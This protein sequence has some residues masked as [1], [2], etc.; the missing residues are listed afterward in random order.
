MTEIKMLGDIIQKDL[1]EMNERIDDI[2][3]INED[4]GED[5]GDY[6][7][8]VMERNGMVDMKMYMEKVLNLIRLCG[9]ELMEV[10]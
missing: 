1:D 9:C 7:V 6:D 10:N 5:D 4:M 8:S 2:T 3:I